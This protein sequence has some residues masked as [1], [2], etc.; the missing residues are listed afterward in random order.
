MRFYNLAT[1][2]ACASL[3]T[4]P[5]LAQGS[6]QAS[7]PTTPSAG[8]HGTK[9]GTGMRQQLVND[10]QKAGFTNVRVEPEVFMVHATNSEGNAVVMRIGPDSMESMT[11]VKSGGSDSKG[12]PHSGT[13]AQ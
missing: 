10:L 5:A 3:F 13:P 12:S 11:A 1:L 9:T 7:T 4:L 2:C 8:S 6:D